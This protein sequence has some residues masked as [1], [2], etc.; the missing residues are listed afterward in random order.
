MSLSAARGYGHSSGVSFEPTSAAQVSAWRSRTAPGP[1]E[2][3]PGLWA[4]AVPV[5]SPITYTL[6][7]VLESPDG[8]LLVDPGWP[9][10]AARDALVDELA[11]IGHSVADVRT[12]VVTHLHPD[13]AGLAGWLVEQAD[14]RLLMH[15]D[16]LDRLLPEG[17]ERKLAGDQLWSSYMQCIGAP[18]D[19]A[20][21]QRA[22]VMP[23]LTQATAD[24][25]TGLSDGDVVTHGDWSLEVLSTPGH[26]RGSIVLLERAQR[27]LLTGDH[28]LPTVTPAVTM[29]AHAGHDILGDF[30]HSLERVRDLPVDEV[31]PGHQYR[32][33][34]LAE[35]VDAMRSHHDLRLV[36]I[37]EAISEQPG[38]SCYDLTQRLT[39]SR[40]DFDAL[41]RRDR[42]MAARETLAHLS[43]LRLAGRVTAHTATT[44]TSWYGG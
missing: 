9:D 2:V 18:A 37:V 35:R 13:H 34:G 22:I 32:F 26:T 33:S 20:V 25:A 16:D 39:W 7:Y 4:V 36:E 10:D 31:L 43:H 24:R 14:C 21:D 30:L 28:V 29:Q 3:R 15:V 8:L 38:A 11:R 41:S 19:V 23:P 40:S 42:A 27:L 1:E 6:C 44:V 12:V 5:P 17:Q